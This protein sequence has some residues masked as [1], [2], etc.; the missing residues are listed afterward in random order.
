M[1]RALGLSQLQSADVA[2]HDPDA[3]ERK[4]LQTI[5]IVGKRM[6]IAAAITL[7]GVVASGLRNFYELVRACGM[8]VCWQQRQSPHISQII[9]IKVSNGDQF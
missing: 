7:E 1:A 5:A 3:E 6:T 4:L 8:P 9:H 2:D